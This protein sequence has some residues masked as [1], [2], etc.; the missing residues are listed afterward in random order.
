MDT[1][2][3]GLDRK[4]SGLIPTQSYMVVN[5]VDNKVFPL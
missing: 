5:T 2:I 1:D 4:L 3:D